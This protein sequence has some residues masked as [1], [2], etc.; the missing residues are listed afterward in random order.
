MGL[1][2]AAPLAGRDVGRACGHDR[3]D[4]FNPRAPC[5]AR[6]ATF[7]FSSSITPFQ[8]THPLRGATRSAAR[9]RACIRHFNPR[10]PCGARR[11]LPSQVM[12]PDLF[13]STRPLRGATG[14]SKRPWRSC[15]FQS[16]RPL[17]GATSAWRMRQRARTY[18]NP[19]APCGVRPF[20]WSLILYDERF[21]STH[22][23]RGATGAMPRLPFQSTHP[24]RGATTHPE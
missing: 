8:S 6:P 3:L 10:A 19:R 16:T 17:R 15:G 21:Q 20:Q 13:Q 2:F 7:A 11:V 22:P 23:L 4:D 24:L 9:S 18:F 12:M 5:G 14:R 1:S